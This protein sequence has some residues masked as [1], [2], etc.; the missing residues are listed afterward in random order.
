MRTRP[1]NRLR[2]WLLSSV[3]FLTAGTAGVE[4]HTLPISYLTLVPDENYLHL[5]LSL[6]PFELTSVPGLEGAGRDGQFLLPAGSEQEEKC[7]RAILATLIV[8]VGGRVVA[9]ETA[10]LTRSFETHHLALRAHYPADAR[11]SAV[12]V[13]SKL[14]GITS[15]AHLTQVT[16][17]SGDVARAARL[18]LQAN[19]VT[20]EPVRGAAAAP[21]A[22]R[23]GSEPAGAVDWRDWRPVLLLVCVVSL[24]LVSAAALTLLLRCLLRE[25]EPRAAIGHGHS[26]RTTP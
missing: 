17:G 25:R 26:L 2:A 24:L 7:A 16:F 9:P 1:A 19:T 8:R 4:A 20:F 13:E 11:T 6:N 18:D 10:G 22:G 23:P 21:R 5:E 12:S 14:A 15:G 3:V